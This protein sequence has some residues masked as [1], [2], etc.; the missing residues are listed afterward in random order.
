MSP[1]APQISV[2]DRQRKIR[3]RVDALKEFASRALSECLK[4]PGIRGSDLERIDEIAIILVSNRRMAELHREFLGV[5]G[6]TDVITFQHGEIFISTEMARSNARRFGSSV[7][8]ELRLYIAHGLLHL[9][10]F[11]DKDPV[12]AALMRRTQAK[13]VMAATRR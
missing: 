3:L 9:H 10:R 1:L 2:Y 8:Q 12:R 4:I 7:E 11:D 6:P 5:S 13:L